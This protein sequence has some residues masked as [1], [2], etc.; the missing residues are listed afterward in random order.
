MVQNIPL[1]QPDFVFY[2]AL[3]LVP[4]DVAH[5][6]CFQ[7]ISWFIAVA[8]GLEGLAQAAF[9]SFPAEKVKPMLPHAVLFGRKSPQQPPLGEQIM[10]YLLS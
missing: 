10:P 6:T 2:A 7:V 9:V 1:R 5:Y 4:T 3:V 8:V